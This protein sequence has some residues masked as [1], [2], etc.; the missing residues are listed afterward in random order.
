L[1][2]LAANLFMAGIKSVDGHPALST[3]TLMADNFPEMFLLSAF[4]LSDLDMQLSNKS[5][6]LHCCSV[7]GRLTAMN[8][9]AELLRRHLRHYFIRPIH[10]KVHKSGQFF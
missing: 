9:P 10:I 3:S 5:K 8:G 2:D 4:L 1:L 6:F 7:T